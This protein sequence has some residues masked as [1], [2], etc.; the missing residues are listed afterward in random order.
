MIAVGSLLA[1]AGGPARAATAERVLAL[2]GTTAAITVEA[3]DRA[4]ALAV[5]ER[6]VGALLAAEGRLSTWREDTE[7][8]RLNAAPAGEA[9]ELSPRLA[10]EL[11]AAAR[12]WRA[13]GGAFDPGIGALAAAWGLRTGGRR[14]GT[15][16]RAEALA[17]SGLRWL[18]LDGRRATRLHPG[19]RVDEGGFGKGAALAAAVEAV[20][21]GTRAIL[22]LGGQLAVA[23]PGAAVEVAIAD[24]RDRARPVLRFAIDGGSVATSG[25]SERRLGG[26]G[27]SFGHLLDPGTGE[28]ARDFGSLTVWAPDAL[29]ADA[30]SKLF[31]LGPEAAVAWAAA[32]PGIEVVAI[33]IDGPGLRVRATRGLAGRLEPL[34]PDLALDLLGSLGSLDSL[35]SLDD[36]PDTLDSGAR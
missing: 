18:A 5:S 25:N 28:P 21:P 35:D 4:A 15:A 17:A 16:E 11:A 23:G 29:A 13:T 1:L 10:S 7:L 32:R 19:L 12:W 34:V 6:A 22:D 9:V 26:G 20:G 3:G 31:V 27:S 8:A 14:P 24:P 36:S 30:L 33:E 2:M